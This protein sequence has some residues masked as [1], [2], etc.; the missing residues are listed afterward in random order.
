M[1]CTAYVIATKNYALI[2]MQVWLDSLVDSVHLVSIW[3]KFC[4]QNIPEALAVDQIEAFLC[5]VN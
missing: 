2:A 5:T 3:L 1:T 4:L